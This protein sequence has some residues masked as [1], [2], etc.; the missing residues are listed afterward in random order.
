[1]T[2]DEKNLEIAA[3]RF[4]IIS[5]FVT[6][7]RMDYGEKEKLIVE[8][9]SRQYRI[10]NSTQT[11]ISKSTIKSWIT[12]YRFAGNRINGLMPKARIDKGKY[13][14]LDPSIQMAIQEIKRELP[15]ITG[16]SLITELQ[17]RKY[18]SIH[19]TVNLSV[20]YK[21]LKNENLQKPKLEHDR[22]AFEAKL[23]NEMWQS[24]VLHGPEAYV[25]GKKIK[26]YLIAILDD[27][28]RLAVHAKFFLSEG[29]AD[30]KLCFKSAIEKRGLPQKIY[31]DNG[32]CYKALNLEQITACLGIGI[33]HTPPYTPQGRGKIERWFRYVR[34]NFL[35]TCTKDLGL[36]E[37]NRLFDIWVDNYNNRIHSATEQTGKFQDR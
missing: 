14:S 16:I 4:G 32:S 17:H 11:S 27:H 9:I 33:A 7:S 5:E 8:K 12:N 6:G 18:L 23:P 20:L 24:D 13:R 31:I 22:R 29:L 19:E 15:E 28:S 35:Y 2:E 30:F 1:M 36:D 37:L 26:S 10:P 3:F 25:A 21:F 34:E